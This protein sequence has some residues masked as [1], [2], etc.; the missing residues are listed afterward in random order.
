M[1]SGCFQL[2]HPGNPS[3]PTGPQLSSASA[4]L[5]ASMKRHPLVYPP[6]SQ[7]LNCLELEISSS[8]SDSDHCHWCGVSSCKPT[9]SC[10]HNAFSITK[11]SF[12]SPQYPA[13]QNRGH[14][15]PVTLEPEL[16][17]AEEKVTHNSST[18]HKEAEKDLTTQLSIRQNP[19]NI[20]V[21][22]PAT[23]TQLILTNLLLWVMLQVLP[24]M[25]P[26]KAIAS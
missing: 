1:S 2:L 3:C 26:S 10:N 19:H 5:L 20:L 6:H 7:P 11:G 16:L 12:I 9:S 17:L 8:S 4:T 22:K 14:S 23:A 25:S 24:C 18:S 13:L 15:S 21:V